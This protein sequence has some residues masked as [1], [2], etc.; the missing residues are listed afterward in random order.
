M[1]LLAIP[2]FYYHRFAAKSRQ[3]LNLRWKCCLGARFCQWRRNFT[4]PS[5][6]S[7]PDNLKIGH[8]WPSRTSRAGTWQSWCGSCPLKRHRESTSP[9]HRAFA[10]SLAYSEGSSLHHLINNRSRFL[11]HLACYSPRTPAYVHHAWWSMAS[12]WTG[13]ESLWCPCSQTVLARKFG[14]L[15][16]SLKLGKPSL[17][18]SYKVLIKQELTNLNLKKTR[19]KDTYL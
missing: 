9:Y 11:N 14:R 1:V 10:G 18:P 3:S 7:C 4:R 15:I 6:A 19:L 13:A 12:P 5:A 8:W 2:V 17:W 16:T